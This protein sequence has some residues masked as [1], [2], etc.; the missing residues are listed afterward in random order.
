M[1]KA[2]RKAERD[3]KRKERELKKKKKGDKSEKTEDVEQE[4]REPPNR[5]ERMLRRNRPKK[6]LGERTKVNFKFIILGS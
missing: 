2:Q 6:T 4:H 1:E 5:L 3:A